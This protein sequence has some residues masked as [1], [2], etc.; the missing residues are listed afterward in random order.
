MMLIASSGT[1]EAQPSERFP[2]STTIL[3]SG[4]RYQGFDLGG[5]TELLRIDA[6]LMRAE[7]LLPVLEEEL[8]EYQQAVLAYERALGEA[9]A[10]REILEQE[11]ARLRENWE[12]ENR[13]RLECEHSPD[14]F[15]L[16]GWGLAGAFG[17]ATLVLG[18]VVG[19]AL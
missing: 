12:E 2:D 3:F 1:V 11:R 8:S 13:L 6:D 10:A 18:L 17:V 15:G 7:R 4:E 16:I 9:D 19:F 14:F 5:F